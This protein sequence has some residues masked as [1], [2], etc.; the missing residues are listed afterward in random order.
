MIIGQ[1]NS[2]AMRFY[3]LEPVRQTRSS[4]NILA[5]ETSHEPIDTTSI[6]IPTCKN[7]LLKD[8][9]SLQAVVTASPHLRELDLG[10]DLTGCPE[11][12]SRGVACVSLLRN[13]EARPASGPGR[14]SAGHGWELN[15]PTS[16]WDPPR[17][18][19]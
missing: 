3:I 2:L 18:S 1:A 11:I 7:S 14:E 15:G 12:T 19:G 17:S 4:R 9:H 13:L 8:R 10:L 16:T 6:C 5:N